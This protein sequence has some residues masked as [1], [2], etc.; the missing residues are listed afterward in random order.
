MEK[1]VA[2]KTLQGLEYKLCGW[3]EKNVNKKENPI[4]IHADTPVNQ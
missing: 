3:F 2:I 1:I 4:K